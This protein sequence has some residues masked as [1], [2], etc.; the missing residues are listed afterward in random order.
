M[1][2]ERSGNRDRSPSAET[3][4]SG[5]KTSLQDGEVTLRLEL[6]LRS[7]PRRAVP[8]LLTAAEWSK[9]VRALRLTRREA[10]VSRR[11]LYDERA[12]SLANDLGLSVDTIRTY[13]N[14]VFRKL[15]VRSM[16][17]AIAYA[18]SVYVQLSRAE[19]SGPNVAESLA[20]I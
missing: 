5:Q 13:R 14:R 4:I 20:R 15:D 8:D 16:T 2:A 9:L 19:T 6:E 10:D 3:V 11:A 17:Q 12:S 7:M 18:F 1:N